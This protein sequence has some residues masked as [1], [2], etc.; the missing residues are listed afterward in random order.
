MIT[1]PTW[2]IHQVFNEQS[3]NY[4]TH[5]VNEYNSLELEINLPIEKKLTK[6]VDI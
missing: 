4:H 5:G 3:V 2:M 1:E 6:G